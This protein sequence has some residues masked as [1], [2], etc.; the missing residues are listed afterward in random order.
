MP[1]RRI[2]PM[3]L[4]MDSLVRFVLCLYFVISI[5]EPYLNGIIGTVT[6]YYMFFVM[7]V[8]LWRDGFQLK[9]RRIS[10]AYI[11]WL[12]LKLVSLLWSEDFR[13]PQLHMISQLGMVLYLVVLLSREPDKKT[14]DSI[15]TACWLASVCLGVLAIFFSGAYRGH[16]EAR[17][18][19]V[20]MGVEI[21]PNNQAALLLIGVALSLNDLF[22]RKRRIGVSAVGLIINCYACFQTSSRAS[23]LTMGALGMFCVL[24]SPEKRKFG[25]VLRNA[26][27]LC[28]AV[29]AIYYITIKLLPEAN[30]ERLFDFSGY[31]GGSERVWLWTT[32]WSVYSKDLLTILFGAGWGTVTPYLNGTV[33][34]NTFLA[35][36]CNVG[37]IGT[38]L[39]MVPIVVIALRMLKRK[40]PMSVLLLGAQFAPS[41]FIE[42][43]NKR[44]FWNAILILLMAYLENCKEYGVQKGRDRS[45]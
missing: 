28:C 41:F 35:M 31:E 3:K 21:D 18:V 22:Y 14:L 13:I 40:E 9:L 1:T 32:A 16:A 20:I 38:L 15:E 45:T 10:L 34:H 36:L 5:F 2:P 33:V 27:L 17:Q 6:K 19:L 43:I 39:F 23:L 44:F 42:A 37:L 30:M 12:M 26:L 29:V 7:F 8:L 25:L 24:Y 4:T 11:A